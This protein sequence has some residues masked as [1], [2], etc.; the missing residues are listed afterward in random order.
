MCIGMCIGMCIDLQIDICMA[1]CADMCAD[2]CTDMC[3]DMWTD[4]YTRQREEEGVRGGRG[5]EEGGGGSFMDGVW[6][7]LPSS[8]KASLHIFQTP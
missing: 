8:V 6:F 7:R 5:R 3:A 2:M 4:M 1:M